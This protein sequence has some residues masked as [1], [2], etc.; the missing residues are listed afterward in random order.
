MKRMTYQADATQEECEHWHDCQRQIRQLQS[1]RALAL[2]IS[3]EDGGPET[4]AERRAL[5]QAIEG[6]DRRIRSLRSEMSRVEQGISNR[7]WNWS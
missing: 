4:A 2:R 3:K 6:Y 7:K 5:A 1:D